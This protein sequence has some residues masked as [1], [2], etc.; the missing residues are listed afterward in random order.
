MQRAIAQMQN[1]GIV[2]KDVQDAIL[3][4]LTAQETARQPLVGMARRL[5]GE[6]ADANVTDEQTS[7]ALAEF[8][9]A[10]ADDQVRYQN[11]LRD[12]DAKINYTSKP[13]LEAFLTMIGVI[14]PEASAL[15]RG[16]RIFSAD[17]ATQR[18]DTSA[19]AEGAAN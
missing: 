11:A 8:R 15:G 10:V 13:R 17:R 2:E 19:N 5:N 18:P 16:G 14:G 12:L 6:L 9:K 3:A 1:V 7:A 4:F